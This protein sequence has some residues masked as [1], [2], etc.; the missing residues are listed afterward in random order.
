MHFMLKTVTHERIKD[1]KERLIP[2]VICEWISETAKE[3][4]DA[5]RLCKR[6]HRIQKPVRRWRS[7][8]RHQA[9]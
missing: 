4:M 7:R 8:C 9:A 5:G 1:S 6:S 2:T 3:N